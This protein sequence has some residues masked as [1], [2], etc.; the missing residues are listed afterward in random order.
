MTPPSGT[1]V[2]CVSFTDDFQLSGWR[3]RTA[4][5]LSSTVR[6]EGAA[7]GLEFPVLLV[8]L[9]SRFTGSGRDNIIRFTSWK[10]AEFVRGVGETGPSFLISVF[11]L[12]T[13]FSGIG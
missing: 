5:R 7:G 3:R 10:S 8:A 1:I 9:G 11:T 4:A 2:A 13:R 12:V 6:D